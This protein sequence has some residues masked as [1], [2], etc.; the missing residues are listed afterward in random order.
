MKVLVV[1]RCKNGR[2]APFITEQVEA[3]EKQGVECQFF[4]VRGK[5][6]RGYLREYRELLG[7]IRVFRPDLV[8]AHYGLCGLLASFQNRVPVVTTFHGS[9]MNNP[10]V[11]PLSRWAMARSAYSIFVSQKNVEMARPRRHYALIPCGINL[12]D[13]PVMDR[14]D[15]RRKMGLAPDRKYVL[16]AGAFDNKVKN[17]P[18]AKAALARLPGVELLELKGYTRSRVAI[19]MHAVDALLMTSFTEGSPQVVKEAM[20]CGTPVVSVEVGDVAERIGRLPG[21]RIVSREA[22]S[23]AQGVSA[24][25]AFR[26]RT[27]GRQA[28]VDDGLTNEQVASRI[29]EIYR[30]ITDR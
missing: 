5:G 14:D 29:K 17:A 24:A 7:A 23:V 28:L 26:H 1:A 16:F 3:L 30:T 2:Y 6:I 12:D 8:H 11:R 15:A 20:A 4:G 13:Y 25:I 19:L 10:Y 18:L 27:E 9:D 22:S 21:C